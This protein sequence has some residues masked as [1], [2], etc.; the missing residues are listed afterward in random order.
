MIGLPGL[1]VPMKMI[2]DYNIADP[3]EKFTN[4]WRLNPMKL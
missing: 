1:K 3:R 2:S 4:R